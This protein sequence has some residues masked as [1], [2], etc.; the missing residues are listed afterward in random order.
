MISIAY[1]LREIV[2]E[3]D[4]QEIIIEIQLSH[5]L[6]VPMESMFR[7]LVNLS[8]SNCVASTV[9]PFVIAKNLDPKISAI[10]GKKRKENSKKIPPLMTSS[11]PAA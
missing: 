7:P 1:C 10:F 5:K 11:Y 3:V 4:N 6:P 2:R 9:D 8:E